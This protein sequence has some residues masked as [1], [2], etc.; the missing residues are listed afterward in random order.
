MAPAQSPSK[1]LPEAGKQLSDYLS[2][3]VQKPSELT[4]TLSFNHPAHELRAVPKHCRVL[5]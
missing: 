3:T 4:A 2:I 1:I 5:L